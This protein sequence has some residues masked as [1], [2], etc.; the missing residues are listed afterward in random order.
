MR[1]Y[2]FDLAYE[3]FRSRLATCTRFAIVGYA[4]RDG[5]LN[6]VLAEEFDRRPGLPAIVVTNGANPSE[7]A[8]EA[9]LGLPA[10]ADVPIIRNGVEHARTDAQWMR[11]ARA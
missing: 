9:A 6:A 10:D 1:R 8:V 3:I 4:F 5:Y 7:V 11:W 2:P